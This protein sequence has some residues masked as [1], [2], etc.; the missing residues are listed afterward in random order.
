[1]SGDCF[2]AR[3]TAQDKRKNFERGKSRKIHFSERK[4]SQEGEILLFGGV[5]GIL[6]GLFG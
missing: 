4:F 2:F 3:E 6:I 1:V 5:L